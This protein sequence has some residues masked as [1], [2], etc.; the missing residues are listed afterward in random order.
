MADSSHAQGTSTTNNGNLG[1]SWEIGV[2][3]GIIVIFLS[4][5]AA[6]IFQ[7]RRRRLAS[8]IA[9]DLEKT[10]PWRSSTNLSSTRPYSSASTTSKETKELTTMAVEVPDLKSTT[11]PKPAPSASSAIL[12]FT[13]SSRAESF[14]EHPS[15]KLPNYYWDHRS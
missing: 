14:P 4:V 8:N 6:A 2:I 5:I 7:R 9:Q 12:S 13:R 11:I 3:I 1:V 15:Q 10:Q